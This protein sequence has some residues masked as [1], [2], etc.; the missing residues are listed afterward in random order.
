MI[1]G[2]TFHQR[3][4]WQDPRYP[5]TGPALSWGSRIDTTPLHYTAADD[6]IDGDP[7]ESAEDLPAYLRAMQRSYVTVR[8]YSLG[9]NFAVDWIGGVWEIRGF[10]IA[11]AANRGWNH[12]SV[13]ILCLVDGQDPMTPEAVESVRR[14][15]AEIDRRAGRATIVRPHSEIGAT[16]CCGDGIRAQIAAGLITPWKDE[17]IMRAINPILLFDS[18][19]SGQRVGDHVEIRLLVPGDLAAEQWLRVRVENINADSIRGGH[20]RVAGDGAG[21]DASLAYAHTAANAVNV[22]EAN[23]RPVGG[24]VVVQP[25]HCSPHLRV[26]IVGAQREA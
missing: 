18:R 9:Y 1:D 4:S 19:S 3:V 24:A 15:L 16:Q 21:L 20:I 8:K 2:V 17:P 6:L 23:V 25:R 22:D 5:V 14:L 7:G 13:A 12:R 11:C 26:S 10:D